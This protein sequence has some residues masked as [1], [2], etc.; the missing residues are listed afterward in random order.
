MPGLRQTR[1][2]R[3]NYRVT[4]T[5]R[6]V[7]DILCMYMFCTVYVRTD[8]NPPTLFA[9][10]TTDSSACVAMVTWYGSSVQFNSCSISPVNYAL[11]VFKFVK[12]IIYIWRIPGRF[13]QALF[14]FFLFKYVM[15]DHEKWLTTI[16]RF[17]WKFLWQQW[18]KSS[19]NLG[20]YR[21]F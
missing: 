17:F 5:L 12:N 18:S 19:W 13:D 9:M 6:N 20:R 16:F 8:A 15:G 2:K 3:A 14:F 10:L 1:R 21:F 4:F 7:W 11:Y